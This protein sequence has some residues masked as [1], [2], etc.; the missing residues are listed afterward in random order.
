MDF[1]NDGIYTK[2]CIP[3]GKRYFHINARGDA[4][5]CAFVHFAVDNVKND[6]HCRRLFYR[7]HSL[8]PTR[9]RFF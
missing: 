8:K 2:G 5:P 6:N 1:W 9:N 4:E 7:I 3:G